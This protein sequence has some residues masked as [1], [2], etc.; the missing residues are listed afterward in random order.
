MGVSTK[1]YVNPRYGMNEVEQL[2]KTI[3]G[4][5][6]KTEYHAAGGFIYFDYNGEDRMLHVYRGE[7]S[8]CP[9][10]S[11]SLSLNAWGSNMEIMKKFALI[12]GGFLIASDCDDKGE[13]FQDP[14]QGNAEF[15]LR[16]QILERGL[17]HKD[18]DKFSDAVA[19]ATGYKR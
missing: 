17:T 4:T 5:L 19:K 8:G 9:M 1:L 14:H 11:T 2:V 12:V 3:G 18:A 7:G 10:P 15:I 6:K 16:H 13:M